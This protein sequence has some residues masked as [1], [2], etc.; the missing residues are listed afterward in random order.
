MR[1][2]QS[3]HMRRQ[4]VVCA[5]IGAQAHRHARHAH[6]NH[7]VYGAQFNL[8]RLGH[9]RQRARRIDRHIAPGQLPAPRVVDAHIAQHIGAGFHA[10]AKLH[11]KD[12]QLLV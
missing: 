7:R 9:C 6:L 1:R 2:Q 12:V 10:F 4:R 11:R 8:G 3:R 5:K